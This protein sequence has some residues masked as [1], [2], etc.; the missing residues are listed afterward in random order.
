MQYVHEK[1]RRAALAAMCAMGR[2]AHTA[3]DESDSLLDSILN[4]AIDYNLIFKIGKA[5]FLL[6]EDGIPRTL[7][8]RNPVSW[9]PRP[10]T[11]MALYK[12]SSLFSVPKTKFRSLSVWKNGSAYLSYGPNQILKLTP[13]R[14]IGH[15]CL[16]GEDG[17]LISPTD[18]LPNW[19]EDE[20]SAPEVVDANLFRDCPISMPVKALS[21]W[22]PAVQYQVW[23]S[24]LALALSGYDQ[25]PPIILWT[26]GI[27]EG[28]FLFRIT[29][30]IL[31][32]EPIVVRKGS[33]IPATERTSVRLIGDNTTIRR[34]LVPTAFFAGE[35][36]RVRLR[37]HFLHFFCSDRADSILVEDVEAAATSLRASLLKELPEVLQHTR[38]PQQP[39]DVWKSYIKQ[40]IQQL[41]P[42]CNPEIAGTITKWL[43]VWSPV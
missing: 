28:E 27:G 11:A 25:L 4:I 13:G 18:H 29:A 7:S 22:S 42:S 37:H 12:R 23:R 41:V 33:Q 20:S 24:W 43:T 30:A 17:V 9:I 5:T 36:Q 19:L 15:F 3:E 1:S 26:K 39:K 38:R 2:L 10:R 40:S 32:G 16:P 35:R 8:Q 6:D 34:T 31:G 14:Q 21:R